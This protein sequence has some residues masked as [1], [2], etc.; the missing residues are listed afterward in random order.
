MMRRAADAEWMEGKSSD[1][2]L[3]LFVV[4]FRMNEFFSIRYF[5]LVMIVLY[6]S[7]SQTRDILQYQSEKRKII[8]LIRSWYFILFFLLESVSDFFLFIFMYFYSMIQCFHS[9]SIF[10]FLLKG[11]RKWKWVFLFSNI[12]KILFAQFF[13]LIYC[14]L[15]SDY[16]FKGKKF[17]H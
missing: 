13:P 2:E 9:H 17:L 6:A 16:N 12:R 7:H 11:W 15:S 4:K 14:S 3:E 1:K 10:R 5:Q 8:F